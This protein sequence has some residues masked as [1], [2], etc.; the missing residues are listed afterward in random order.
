MSHFS[1]VV[2][3]DD[4][5]GKLAKAAGVAA[6]GFPDGKDI[7]A[8][9]GNEGVLRRVI[10]ARLTD[11]LAPFDENLE[12][13]PYRDYEDGSPAEY[14]W[15]TSVRRGAESHRQ[16][17]E[18]GA[19]ALALE[20]IIKHAGREPR[21]MAMAVEAVT[22]HADGWAEDFS[23]SE[24]LGNEPSWADVARLCSEKYGSDEDET[25]L[26]VSEDGSHAYTMSS[27]NPQAKWDYWRI[28]GRWGGYFPYH[29]KHAAKVIA[30]E[31]GWDS[32]ETVK[33]LHCDGGPKSALDLAALRKEMA[34][35]AAKTYAEYRAVVAGTPE[36]LPWS[37]F[38]DNISEGGYTI[39]QARE[40]Y[41]SQP[42]VQALSDS[43]FRYHDDV[44]AEFAV[45]EKVYVERR[46]AQALP[47]Y[48]TVTT[49]G[50]WTAPGRMGW[51]GVSTDS[52]DDRAGY[53]E[54][55]NAY[56]DAL[57]DDA[58]LVVIDCHI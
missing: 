32:P 43:D 33:P 35:Q 10:E 16:L 58:F 8:F 23:W 49:D 45:D 26:L 55:A 4:K 51:F 25:P 7:P 9:G 1:V 47:G 28:G 24:K 19:E 36:A 21:V 54:A 11:V 39:D 29:Q 6:R 3:L 38:A 20:R 13:E 42:R 30:T 50:Q 2:C 17:Q 14:W 27:R 22:E 56:V 12:V 15:V 37:A 5:D 44:I 34:E 53:Y 48:A 31:R 52:T 46:R 57:P 40:E 41:H 18:Q